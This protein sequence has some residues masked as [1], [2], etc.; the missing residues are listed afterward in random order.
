MIRMPRLVF[1]RVADEMAAL[2]AEIAGLRAANAML[3]KAIA[4]ASEEVQR[5]RD[6]L[7][8]RLN[9]NP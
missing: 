4:E 9:A 1:S 7:A 2:R 5:T 8:G 6:A 3:M